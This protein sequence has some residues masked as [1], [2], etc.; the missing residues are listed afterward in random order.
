MGYSVGHWDG[1]VLV[2]ESNGYTDRSWLDYGGHPHTEALR[3]TERVT[4]PTIGR[5]ESQITVVDPTIYFKPIV[6]EMQAALQPD[7]EMIES[8]CEN[9]HESRERMALTQAAQVVEVPADV[10]SRYVGVYDIGG[11]GSAHFAEVV[12]DATSLYFDYDGKGRELLVPLSQTQFSWSGSIVDF[13]PSA[14]G[15]MDM[16]INYAEG[17]ESGSRRASR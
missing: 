5:L 4:R 10:L 9:H 17:Q 13:T 8:V 2:V 12:A 3:I 14:D 16:A 7:T 15:G 1:D 11:M 6:I